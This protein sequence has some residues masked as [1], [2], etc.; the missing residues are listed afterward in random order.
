MFRGI[1]SLTAFCG[2]AHVTIVK[3]LRFKVLVPDFFWA[4]FL[5]TATAIIIECKK[6]AIAAN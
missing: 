3:A 4:K 2:Y 1:I 5:K 6:F